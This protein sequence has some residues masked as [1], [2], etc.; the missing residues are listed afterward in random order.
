MEINSGHMIISEGENKFVFKPLSFF[1]EGFKTVPMN[2]IL[3]YQLYNHY[4]IPRVPKTELATIPID[5][6]KLTGSKQKFI[7][8]AYPLHL[9][10]GEINRL[11]ATEI[12]IMDTVL[13]NTDRKAENTLVDDEGNLYAIDNGFTLGFNTDAER[14]KRP[15]GYHWNVCLYDIEATLNIDRRLVKSIDEAYLNELLHRLQ[16][17]PCPIKQEEDADDSWNDLVTMLMWR[18]RFLPTLVWKQLMEAE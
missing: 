5:S 1:S 8:N 2:E 6:L 18:L 13:G 12:V 15:E 7:T 16:H 4:R 11:H 17:N 9:F 10:N 14:Y 3:A